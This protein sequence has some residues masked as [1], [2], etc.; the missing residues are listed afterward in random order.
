MV[1][2]SYGVVSWF[3]L[4]TLRMLVSRLP[5]V[6]NKDLVF[7]GLAMFTLGNEPQVSS[8]LAMMAGLILVAHI[9]VGLAGALGEV[10]VERRQK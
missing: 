8:L 10:F 1:L 2:P 4:A 6:P 9:A 7:A 5:L 3:M